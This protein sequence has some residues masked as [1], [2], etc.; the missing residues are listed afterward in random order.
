MQHLDREDGVGDLCGVQNRCTY[1]P[2]IGSISAGDFPQVV[3]PPAAPSQLHGQRCI[4]SK[5]T[6]AAECTRRHA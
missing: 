4:T 2:P 5:Q 3:T 6:G 1:A